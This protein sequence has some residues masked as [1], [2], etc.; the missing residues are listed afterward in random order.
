MTL[1][2]D[3]LDRLLADLTAPPPDTG[4]LWRKALESPSAQP[5]ARPS[6]IAALFRTALPNSALAAVLIIV[7]MGGV[8]AA[9]L[10][11]LGSA[12]Q[13]ARQLKDSTQVRGIQQ[14]LTAWA[15]N[16]S[17]ETVPP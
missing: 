1:T 16:N 4:D 15:Q 14:G 17:T 13:S 5:A 12:R 3:N 10:P 2:P 7:V 6:R 11:S 9:V 8:V